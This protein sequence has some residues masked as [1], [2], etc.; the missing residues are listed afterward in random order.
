MLCDHKWITGKKNTQ[1]CSDCSLVFPCK[2]DCAHFDC[3]EF[4]Q[5]PFKCVVCKKPV[6]TDDVFFESGPR[7]WLPHH[8]KC[9]SVY[10]EQCLNST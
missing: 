10:K 9:S 3:I 8:Q 4:K 7:S 2:G 1:I 5:I 6:E